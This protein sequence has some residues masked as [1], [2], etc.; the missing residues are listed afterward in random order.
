M[1][2]HIGVDDESGLDHSIETT[3]ANVHDLTPSDKLLHGEE[4]RVWAD[5]GYQGIEKRQAHHDRKVAWRVCSLASTVWS[6][7]SQFTAA[8][9]R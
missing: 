1:K 6:T 3:S 4:A 8:S 9:F 7:G 5:A 2:L